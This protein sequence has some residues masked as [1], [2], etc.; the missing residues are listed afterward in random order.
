LEPDVVIT[1]VVPGLRRKKQEDGAEVSLGYIVSTKQKNKRP[2]TTTKQ[3][4]N[5]NQPT[6]KEKQGKNKE[7]NS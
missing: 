5:K 2:K 4:K 1:P 7:N 6:N 3:N